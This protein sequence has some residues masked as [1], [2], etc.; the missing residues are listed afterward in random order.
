MSADHPAPVGD[1]HGDQR[2]QDAGQQAVGEDDA[3]QAQAGQPVPEA[4]QDHRA[5]QAQGQGPAA[6]AVRG[7]VGGADPGHRGEHR[8]RER[9]DHAAEHERGL[10]QRHPAGHR[11]G[12][13]RDVVADVL[14][15]REAEAHHGGVDD[16]VGGAVEF[17][18]APPQQPGEHQ[19]LEGLLHHRRAD[20]GRDELAVAPA[21]GGLGDVQQPG[22]VE[23]PREQ[24]G[25]ARAPGETED[26]VAGRLGL[27]PVQQQHQRD[28]QRHRQ[29][30][31]RQRD[32]ER[33]HAVP[34]AVD[35]LGHVD[36]QD[37]QR[38]AQPGGH[39]DDQATAV[40]AS[41]D[42]RERVLG[43]HARKRTDPRCG[44][45]GPSRR[46]IGSKQR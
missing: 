2:H 34:G 40:R 46:P 15:H 28:Q 23:D 7:R 6:A 14:H 27:Q 31:Q 45:D 44:W 29:Q 8:V 9:R 26:Q 20:R 33:D 41:L 5:E 42:H 16:P 35:A 1:H 36:A 30:G 43:Q 19:A 13:G 17:L 12:Q 38:A 11:C 39:A 25:D 22:G 37:D 4:V 10:E 18:P 24:R 3:G 21:E 32:Q